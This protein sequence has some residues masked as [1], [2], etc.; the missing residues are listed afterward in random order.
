[1]IK[2]TSYPGSGPHFKSLCIQ[3]YITPAQIHPCTPGQ[4]PQHKTQQV[5]KWEPRL[6]PTATV[7]KALLKGHK[8]GQRLGRSGVSKWEYQHKRVVTFDLLWNQPT[9]VFGKALLG[10]NCNGAHGWS[11]AYAQSGWAAEAG[12]KVR[13]KSQGTTNLSG[14]EFW[15]K[16]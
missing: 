8:V 14:L 1:M 2:T 15:P 9:S 7:P 10:Q 16:V 5:K 4:R 3:N 11:R 12:G 6:H 13:E